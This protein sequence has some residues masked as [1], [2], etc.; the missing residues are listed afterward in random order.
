MYPVIDLLQ[1]A[2]RV[3][4]DDTPLEKLRLSGILRG[5]KLL[6]YQLLMSTDR[7]SNILRSETSG[8]PDF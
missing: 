5:G 4:R 8:A 2:L 3:Q 7:R 1:R 6:Y